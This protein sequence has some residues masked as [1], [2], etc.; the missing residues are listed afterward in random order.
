MKTFFSLMTVCLLAA[1]A[2]A[3]DATA[4]FQLRLVSEKASPTSEPMAI[5][6]K[7]GDHPAT[8][9][10]NVER[11]VLLDQ[12]ALQSANVGTDSFGHPIIEIRFSKSGTAR[13]ADVTRENIGRQLGIVIDGT[14]YSAPS[15]RSAIT[16]GKA[17]ISGSF[18]RAEAQELAKK[19]NSLAAK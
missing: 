4:T 13:F 16:G 1:G 19:L 2:A 3:V 15:I 5:V 14:L 17:Q 18:S 12:T 6:S 7:V 9:V 10:F 11:A 8:N